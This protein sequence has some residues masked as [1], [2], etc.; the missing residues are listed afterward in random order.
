MSDSESFQDATVVK[1]ANVYYDGNVTSRELTVDGQRI[2]LGIILPGQY[3]FPTEE[4]EEITLY[5]GELTV[6]HPD[7]S[8]ETYSDGETFTVPA[9]SEFDIE[10]DAVVDYCCVYH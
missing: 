3:T 9:D 7:G 6:T 2:S 1:E 4:E 8:V 10:T 5:R